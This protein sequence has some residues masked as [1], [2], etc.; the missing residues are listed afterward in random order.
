MVMA[1]QAEIHQDGKPSTSAHFHF[2]LPVRIVQEISCEAREII[3]CQ[4]PQKLPPDKML[5]WFS[6]FR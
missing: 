1:D 4:T 3:Q 2:K 5:M 6:V